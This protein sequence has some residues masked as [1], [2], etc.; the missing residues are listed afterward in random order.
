MKL[1]QV[2]VPALDITASV[3]FYRGLGLK[4]IVSSP[5]YARFECADGDSTFSV[6]LAKDGAA[7]HGAVVY[8][9]CENLDQKVL[10]LKACGYTFAQDPKDESWLWREARLRDPANNEICL[11]WA[12][13]HRRF[14]PWRVQG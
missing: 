12:G 11:Y 10:D 7:S 8:F 4:L 5:H 6:H 13:T 2:T 14:P 1:N 9:E 3:A